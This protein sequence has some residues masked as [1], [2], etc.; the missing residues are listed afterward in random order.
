M[1]KLFS[2]G[3]KLVIFLGRNKKYFTEIKNWD[4]TDIV[5]V[6][7]VQY[8]DL[9]YVYTAKWLTEKVNIHITQLFICFS[10]DEN[11]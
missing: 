2:W 5:L 10:Y 4:I 8:S 11:F 7:G 6:L 9:I 1:C 3:T